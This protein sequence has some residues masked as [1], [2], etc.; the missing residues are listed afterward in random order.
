LR[1]MLRQAPNVIMLGE[2]RDIETAS[3]A[4]N[5]SLTGHLVF[6]TLHTNDAPST[7]TRLRDMGVPPFLLTATLEAVL[8]QRLVRKICPNCREQVIP[9]TETL[10]LL[11]L[12]PDDVL[13]KKFHRGRGC[14]LCNNSGFKGRTALHE[15][16]L[17]N[18]RLRELINTG[19]STEKIRDAALQTG[20]RSLR[21]AGLEKV[22]AGIT[23]IEEVI[24]ETVHE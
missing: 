11:D 13:E 5:A 20:M 21:L 3:I 23:S 18:D 19:S 12:S 22:Y 10:A 6:S 15:L 7:I 9:N 8:S 2:I 1:A 4:I 17:M 16:M 24:R 14:Q